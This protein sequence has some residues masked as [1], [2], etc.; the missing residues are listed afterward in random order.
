MCLI[1][2]D[3]LTIF[4]V[5]FLSLALKFDLRSIHLLFFYKTTLSGTTSSKNIARLRDVFYFTQLYS[6][7][8]RGK[9]A[10]YYQL[11]NKIPK[12]IEPKVI[13]KSTRDAD[14]VQVIIPVPVVL[15][16]YVQEDD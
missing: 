13:L 3:R 12:F 7:K 5:H 10:L 1:F 4:T 16:H 8:H 15:H 6:L 14:F 11:C 2:F 9:T